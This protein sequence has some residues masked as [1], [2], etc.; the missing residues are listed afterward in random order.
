MPNPRTLD[1]NLMKYKS[2]LKFSFYILYFFY[3]YQK[4]QCNL[5][6]DKFIFIFSV[7][8]NSVTELY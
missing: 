7:K 2:F 3:S 8:I 1:L 6:Y 5:A 4:I